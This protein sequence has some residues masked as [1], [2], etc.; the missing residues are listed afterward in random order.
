VAH[1]LQSRRYARPTPA[2][3]LGRGIPRRRGSWLQRIADS[4]RW[5]ETNSARS[6]ARAAR[7][8]TR[9]GRPTSGRVRRHETPDA[10]AA[11]QAIESSLRPPSRNRVRRKIPDPC[12]PTNSEGATSRWSGTV[13][14]LLPRSTGGERRLI[15]LNDQPE[16]AGPPARRTASARRSSGF[17]VSPT[18][19]LKRTPSELKDRQS[20]A[21][22]VRSRRETVNSAQRR[23]DHEH[24]PN[25]AL[26]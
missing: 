9:E 11:W 18:C 22:V 24:P 13:S 23:D 5:I 21:D 19:P 17:S 4:R 20:T 25:E 15:G 26:P 8:R 12:R 6:P 14:L 16:R 10:R 1:Q 7:R 3:D 2:Q